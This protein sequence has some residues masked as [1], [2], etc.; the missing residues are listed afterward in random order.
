MKLIAKSV[1]APGTVAETQLASVMVSGTASGS[2]LLEP[3]SDLASNSAL[4]V[5]NGNVKD[6]V[7]NVGDGVVGDGIGD[8][9]A[10]VDGDYVGDIGDGIVGDGHGDVGDGVV[11]EGVNDVDD[12]VWR[13]A[14]WRR[15]RSR[16]DVG[17]GYR[18][19]C[20]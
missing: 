14:C 7:D 9:G 16:W 3:A 19:Q 2:A 13:R 20:W 8:A 6:G 1:A 17:C 11:G 4:V 10:S 18:Y 5:G 15:R 12:G